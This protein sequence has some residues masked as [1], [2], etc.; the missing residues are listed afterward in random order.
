MM[1]HRSVKVCP[2]LQTSSELTGLSLK[3]LCDVVCLFDFI[4]FKSG[5]LL[6]SDAY[7]S[8][9]ADPASSGDSL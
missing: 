1:S 4:G 8:V 6:I 9:E 7:Q 3:L 2:D 5:I